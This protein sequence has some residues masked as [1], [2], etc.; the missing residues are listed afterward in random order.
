MKIYSEPRLRCLICGVRWAEPMTYICED[1]KCFEIFM[2]YQAKGRLKEL[3]DISEE[4]EREEV[5]EKQYNYQ[6][7][8]QDRLHFSYH[9]S[10]T[11]HGNSQ[12]TEGIKASLVLP[13]KVVSLQSRT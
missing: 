7:L 9:Q 4:D 11:F 8:I 5:D 2:D 1:E 13:V 6:S 10:L 3:L 12:T